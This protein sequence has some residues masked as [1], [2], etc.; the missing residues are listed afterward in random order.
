MILGILVTSRHVLTHAIEVEHILAV[1]T[2]IKAYTNPAAL[3]GHDT[4]AIARTAYIAN[5]NTSNMDIF[6]SMNTM[7]KMN[8]IF[9]SMM[10]SI[11]LILRLAT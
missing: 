3:T 1:S 9:M 7:N 10:I 4:A 2:T 5:P 6:I 8:W 11:L